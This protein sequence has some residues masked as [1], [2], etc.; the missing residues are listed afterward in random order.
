MNNVYTQDS[1]PSFYIGKVAISLVT[2]DKAL[3]LIE[4]KICEMLP[5]YI[6]VANV[7]TT[8]LSQRD[9]DFCRI[10]N[11]SLLTVPDGIPLVWYA[12][13]MGEKGDDEPII[14]DSVSHLWDE[15]EWQW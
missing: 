13:I 8:V 12:K 10:Q 9:G 11:E 4:E 7:E 15:E 6:C 2:M 5:G 1:I 3:K 14:D